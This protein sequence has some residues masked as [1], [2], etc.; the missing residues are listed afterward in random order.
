MKL[1]GVLLWLS[2]PV[3]FAAHSTHATEP[4]PA[5]NGLERLDCEEHLAQDFSTW[6]LHDPAVD[7]L[8]RQCVAGKGTGSTAPEQA[9]KPGRQAKSA[10]ETH[11][12]PKARHRHKGVNRP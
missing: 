5:T 8:L 1:T 12:R 7:A 3:S 9:T 2:V 6:D 4:Q 11:T 10:Q